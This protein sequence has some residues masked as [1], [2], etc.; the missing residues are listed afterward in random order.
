[1]SRHGSIEEIDAALDYQT[2]TIEPPPERDGFQRNRVFRTHGGILCRIEWWANQS[3]LYI[4][5]IGLQVAFNVVRRT[6]T[7]PNQSAMNLQFY[8]HH[9]NVV[10]VLSIEDLK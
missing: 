6:N 1:M 4:D 8:D 3:Y 2:I 5:S 9:D 7:W 10:A